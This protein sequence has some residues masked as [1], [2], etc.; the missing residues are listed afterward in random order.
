MKLHGIQNLIVL[1]HQRHSDLLPA[2]IITSGMEEENHKIN[3]RLF[4]KGFVCLKAFLNEFNVY[5]EDTKAMQS[6]K[7]IKGLFYR[8]NR[9]NGS[10]QLKKK[11]GETHQQLIIVF[12]IK[13]FT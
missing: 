7:I 5:I 2:I 6:D 3:Y 9:V 4:L 11:S 10:S 12:S 13:M 1:A 8:V